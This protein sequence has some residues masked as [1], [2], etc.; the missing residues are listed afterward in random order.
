MTL[1]AQTSER[2][3]AQNYV[4]GNSLVRDCL[5]LWARG[6]GAMVVALRE[7]Q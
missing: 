4:I 3:L 7:T 1:E 6:L 5:P 2:S